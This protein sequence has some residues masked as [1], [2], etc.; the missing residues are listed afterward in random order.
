MRA[1]RSVVAGL[2]LGAAL[3]LALG[4]ATGAYE[5]L[6]VERDLAHGLVRLALERGGRSMATGG[7]IGAAIAAAALAAA[8][9]LGAAFG[10]RLPRAEAARLRFANGLARRQRALALLACSLAILALG[11][12]GGARS[13]ARRAATG[14]PNLLVIVMDTVRADRLSSFG[15]ARPTT[16]ELDAFAREAIRFPR[17]YAPAPWTLPSHA[18]LFTGSFPARHGATQEHWS[19]ARRHAT[20][21][22]VLRDAGYATFAASANPVV[23]PVSQLDQGFAV[24]R[25]VWRESSKVFEGGPAAHPVNRSFAAFLRDADRERPF[26]AFLN[27]MDAHRPY[28]PPI[29]FLARFARARPSSIAAARV[30]SRVWTELYLEGP[31]PPEDVRLISDLY[32]AELAFLSASIGALLDELRRD[33]RY[34]ATLVAITSDHGEHLGEHGLFDHVFSLYEPLLHV[35]LLLR[36]PGGARAG[37]TDAR[38][39]QLTDLLPTLLAA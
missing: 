7:A 38:P 16:P 21:A 4:A 32:D 17:F 28:T 10:T 18:S 23:G 13:A 25:E 3:G 19:L 34:D 33:G 15:Y 37:T 12:W 11:A 1:M 27:Y 29:E 39:G 22:E 5:V 20:L 36:L 6:A 9:A 35:P 31:G 30:G 14:H 26:F 24:F 8:A 2:G